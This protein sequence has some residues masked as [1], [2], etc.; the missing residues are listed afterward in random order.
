MRWACG[1]R[2]TG[3]TTTV[4]QRSAG[5]ELLAAGPVMYTP[6]S[7]PQ[8]QHPPPP[9]TYK[10]QK[11][12]TQAF[13]GRG[14]Q[15]VGRGLGRGEDN[16]QTPQNPPNHQIKSR[17]SIPPPATQQHSN[18]EAWLLFFRLHTSLPR[19]YHHHQYTHTTLTHQ[20][21]GNEIRIINPP[22]TTTYT[23]T[24]PLINQSID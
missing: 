21:Y 22:L 17:N 10:T 23:H 5:A 15:H 3:S 12:S 18:R 24:T 13:R 9:L 8:N 6:T 19:H 7:A 4:R 11:T 2:V 1:H 16:G 14:G 20:Q